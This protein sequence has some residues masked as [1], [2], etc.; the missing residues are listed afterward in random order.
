[1]DRS[2][3]IGFANAFD[4]QADAVFTGIKNTVFT[5]AVIFEF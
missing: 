1:M 5:G 3:E 4:S 2:F